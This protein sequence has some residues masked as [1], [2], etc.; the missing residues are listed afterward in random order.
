MSEENKEE[1]N[2]EKVLNNLNEMN[3]KL[4]DQ[5]L[6]LEEAIK[7]YTE[8]MNLAKIGAKRIEEAE[9]QI[10]EFIVDKEGEV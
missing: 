9:K 5:A 1:M 10:G 7:I 2:L 8:A 4:A 3:V 6:E